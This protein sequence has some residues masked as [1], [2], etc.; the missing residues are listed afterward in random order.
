MKKDTVWWEPTSLS[1]YWTTDLSQN[2]HKQEVGQDC[3][4][5]LFPSPHSLAS[6]PGLRTKQTTDNGFRILTSS[7]LLDW[8]WGPS[9]S[10]PSSDSLTT[11]AW[12]LTCRHGKD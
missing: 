12:C 9:L 11:E 6:Y 10:P 4:H 2:H 1:I 7:K 3:A 8:G 5:S